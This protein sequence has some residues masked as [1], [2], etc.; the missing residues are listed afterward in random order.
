MA[1]TRPDV[2]QIIRDKEA[3]TS[4]AGLDRRIGSLAK[5]TEEQTAKFERS[6]RTQVQA[7]KPIISPPKKKTT[8]VQQRPDVVSIIN[9]KKKLSEP[10]SPLIKTSAEDALPKDP[11]DLIKETT[12]SVIQQGFSNFG[13]GVFGEER[14]KMSPFGATFDFLKKDIIGIQPTREE[15][16]QTK[17]GVLGAGAAIM[18]AMVSAAGPMFLEALLALDEDFVSTY[19]DPAFH[20]PFL[21][22]V[23]IPKL[24]AQ[25]QESGDRLFG[26][27]IND[28]KLLV[29]F[30]EILFS[31]KNPVRKLEVGNDLVEGAFSQNSV[32]PDVAQVL[33]SDAF[34]RAMAVI[35]LIDIVYLD[36][37]VSAVSVSNLA[38]E[39]PTSAIRT[40]KFVRFGDEAASA[41]VKQIDEGASAAA[42]KI[43]DDFR[44][45]KQSQLDEIF[46]RPESVVR[47]LDE[48]V[49]PIQARKALDDIT[50]GKQKILTQE[51][52]LAALKVELEDIL[53]RRTD[54][55]QSA[56]K[57]DS[58]KF[59][60]EALPRKLS[61]A[62]NRLSVV[63]RTPQRTVSSIRTTL[64]TVDGPISRTLDDLFSVA[65]S[66]AKEA[67]LPLTFDDVSSLIEDARLIVRSAAD[68]GDP[69]VESAAAAQL[70]DAFTS[71]SASLD[72]FDTLTSRL[73]DGGQVI[74]Q[75]L[76][77]SLAERTSSRLGGISSGPAATLQKRVDKLESSL[78]TARTQQQRLESSPIVQTLRSAVQAGIAP[79]QII[80]PRR[81]ITS[82]EFLQ[83]FDTIGPDQGRDLNVFS[84][85]SLSLTDPT[86]AAQTLD[87]AFSGIRMREFVQPTINAKAAR[88]TGTQQKTD[89]I[90]AHLKKIGIGMPS[91]TIT[92]WVKKTFTRGG[93]KAIDSSKR[94][95]RSA[96]GKKVKLNAA[97]R[98]LTDFGRALTD[99]YFERLNVQRVALGN[100]PIPFR[101]NYITHVQDL[102]V[103]DRIG[104]NLVT[105][106]NIDE[107]IDPL[108]TASRTKQRASFF[109]EKARV[110]G[111]Q[112][113]E[114]YVGA[115][116]A[117]VHIAERELNM[118]P[119]AAKINAI[120]P[121]L[122]GVNERVYWQRFVNEAVLEGETVLDKAI[123][124]IAPL[125]L[126]K[127]FGQFSGITSRGALL[128]NVNVAS[129]QPTTWFLNP[130][131]FKTRHLM[132]ATVES[133]T[134][135]G[136]KFVVDNSK[137]RTIRSFERG[138]VEFSN[139][140]KV[141]NAVNFF[142]RELDLN[143]FDITWT[144]AY[145]NGRRDIINPKTGKHLEHNEAV[146]Y[147]DI[148]AGQTQAM[149]DKL[150]VPPIL[151]SKTGR[152]AGQFGTFPINLWKQL[153][154]DIRNVAGDKGK[155]RAIRQLLALL[156][157]AE[158][159]NMAYEY[160]G[161]QKPYDFISTDPEETIKVIPFVGGV[162][163]FGPPIAFKDAFAVWDLV[164]GSPRDQERAIKQLKKD[165]VLLVP[166]GNQIRKT[167]K[168]VQAISDG[169]T[170]YGTRRIPI[171]G[172]DEEI[173]AIFLGPF[174]TTAAREFFDEKREKERNK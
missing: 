6:T 134:P 79:A 164:F 155:G 52:R 53:R 83:R 17:P 170:T 111:G 158:A 142:T 44:A 81:V 30:L 43:A 7:D 18:Q 45:A 14:F 159:A 140:T 9:K 121:S 42:K 115:L 50:V 76:S 137:L 117:Y 113:R 35:D 139:L 138:D 85:G 104:V 73:A 120:I 149:Y 91:N 165:L 89:A 74:R 64:R 100:K 65:I 56:V 123:D 3:V 66:S 107:I 62:E 37:I 20:I 147:A 28:P 78:A 27:V 57:V 59:L 84:R 11:V 49:T 129:L 148:I 38:I 102:T 34:I 106:K 157:G 125:R 174:G 171:E 98:D 160:V 154:T 71:F 119:V 41:A 33:S 32:L 118:N 133:L 24:S 63:S 68:E 132:S 166:A 101:E 141:E 10:K 4:L 1:T 172:I 21:G 58:A 96:E 39:G 169:Y 146:H 51:E 94:M 25:Q 168:G 88:L 46:N 116:M 87:G 61:A 131:K 145:K 109:A 150:L 48:G 29:P 136:R 114:D 127:H 69:F 144:G 90:A 112:T 135:Q 105:T 99:N 95:F 80:S 19:E 110:G 86:R 2:L 36:E 31:P 67:D 82:P 60:D 162:R 128:A 92:G 143:M 22:D 16:E 72:E 103:L 8:P 167:I 55:A 40:G 12:K 23:G 26:K 5:K 122:P 161:L 124:A 93:K 13:K 156:A 77:A 47:L 153:T 70:E 151:R 54:E 152:L 108:G 130:A 126:T 97:E 163:T 75:E 173:R 15:F